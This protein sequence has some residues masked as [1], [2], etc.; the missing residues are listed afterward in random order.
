MSVS[1]EEEAG[2]QVPTNKLKA[3]GEDIAGSDSR[4]ATT[5]PVSLPSEEFLGIP[6]RRRRREQKSAPI[7]L[8]TGGR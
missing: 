7:F 5:S 3:G 1:P 4:V 8:K 6:L 2:R